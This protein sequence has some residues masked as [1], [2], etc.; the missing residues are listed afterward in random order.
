MNNK[1][2]VIVSACLV[3]LNCRYDGQSAYKREVAERE[4]ITLI[5]VCPE[6]LGGL[7]TPR[8]KAE[9]T[10]GSGTD[11]LEGS[12]LVIDSKFDDLTSHFTKGANEVL[13][14]ARTANAKK[15]IL[16]EK[17][18]SCG[19]F[20]IKR[21]GKDIEGSGVLTVLLKREGIEVEGV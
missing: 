21:N 9:I 15:A 4:D 19:V 6:Q 5:P 1:A 2:P 20:A 17:S 18:P 11:V 14:I 8:P 7:P 16:K 3:G 12:S 10:E 13:K